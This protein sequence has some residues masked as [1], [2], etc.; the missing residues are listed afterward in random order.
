VWSDGSVFSY[1]IDLA[2]TTPKTE[3][4]GQLN[5]QEINDL[6][7]D[8]VQAKNVEHRKYE[9]MT[10]FMSWA[11]TNGAFRHDWSWSMGDASIPKALSRLETRLNRNN[12]TL[13][14][15]NPPA[16][17]GDK[18]G[19]ADVFL[20]ND[21]SFSLTLSGAE[22]VEIRGKSAGPLGLLS[23][24]EGQSIPLQGE[25]GEIHIIDVEGGWLSGEV[26]RSDRADRF[27]IPAWLEVAP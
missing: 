17:L 1:E 21:G 22:N 12:L 26:K 10:T 19:R 25:V 15:G 9:N 3:Y 23:E 24:L 16:L 14:P 8:L 5:E 11:G 13:T 27:R 18:Q 2:R 7:L 20:A 6:L 4:L